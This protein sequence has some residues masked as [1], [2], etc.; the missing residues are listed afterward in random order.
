MLRP[1]PGVQPGD[2]FLIRER[3]EE[4]A[5]GLRSGS[6]THNFVTVALAFAARHVI[7][8]VEQ[9]KSTSPEPPF[10]RQDVLDQPRRVQMGELLVERRDALGQAAQMRNPIPHARQRQVR[11][12]QPG[13]RVH[14]VSFAELALDRQPL[15]LSARR[16]VRGNRS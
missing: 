3:V 5:V 6:K 4:D 13:A 16:V 14:A 2:Q 7:P 8:W 11:A 10:D 12:L 1:I 9:A 15:D